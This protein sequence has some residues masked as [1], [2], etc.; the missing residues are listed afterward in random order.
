MARRMSSSMI[1]RMIRLVV[2]GAVEKGVMARELPLRCRAGIG[3]NTYI[4]PEPTTQVP[5]VASDGWVFSRRYWFQCQCRYRSIAL[6][7]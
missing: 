2:S 3:E 7:M 5:Q 4:G 6:T 1:G